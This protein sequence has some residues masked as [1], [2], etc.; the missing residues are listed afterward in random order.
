MIVAIVLFR[1]RTHFP[2]EGGCELILE[3]IGASMRCDLMGAL[4]ADTRYLM[5]FQDSGDGD[6]V[7]CSDHVATIND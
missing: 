5:S 2:V 4:A 6:E 1:C 3:V 7:M